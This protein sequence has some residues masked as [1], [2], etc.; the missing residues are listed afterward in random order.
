MNNLFDAAYRCIMETDLTEK[1]QLTQTTVQAWQAGE[2]SLNTTNPAEPILMPGLPPNLCLVPPRE[3]PRRSIATP[4]G[5]AALLHALTHI[6]FNAINLAWDA[7]YRFRDL[8]KAFYDDWVKVAD[9]EAMHF[10]LLHEQLQQL[11]Y[12]YGDLTAHNGLW[13]MAVKTQDDVLMRM[14]L[15]PRL[16]EA[17]GLDAVPPIIAKAKAQGLSLMIENLQIILRDEIGHVKIGS[18]WFFHCCAERGLNPET[19]F[20]NLVTQHFTSQI[21]GPFNI[22]ARLAAGFSEQELQ[23]LEKL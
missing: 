9:E 5:Q 18:H 22:E 11:G 4:T 19:T 14:A 16:L 12:K 17:R 13:E 3:V 8:P 15:I 7:V 10:V 2:L 20:Q 23:N 6:E 21:K 1:V